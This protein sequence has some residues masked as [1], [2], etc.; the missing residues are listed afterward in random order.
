[1]NR[2]ATFADRP[3]RNAKEIGKGGFGIVN[4]TE[5]VS[6]RVAL[7]IVGPGM[8][9]KEA[10]AHSEAARQALEMKN[11]TDRHREGAPSHWEL[12]V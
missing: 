1:M 10:G 2:L 12:R 7:N 4:M 5:Q 8:D 9:T 6:R 3:L 11:Q